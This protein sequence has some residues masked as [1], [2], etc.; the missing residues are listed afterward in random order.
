MLLYLSKFTPSGFD[1]SLSF[2]KFIVL[3]ITPY[4]KFFD[5]LLSKVKQILPLCPFTEISILR[6]F[7]IYHLVLNFT[8]IH[9]IEELVQYPTRIPEHHG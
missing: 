3:F 8:I 5:Y 1:L 6:N 9:D 2:T 4:I 7:N